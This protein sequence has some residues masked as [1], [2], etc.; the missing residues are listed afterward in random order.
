VQRELVLGARI[1]TRAAPGYRIATMAL[2]LGGMPKPASLA[3]RGRWGGQSYSLGGVFLDG[4]EPAPSPFGKAFDPGA[5]PRIRS[6]HLPWNGAADFTWEFWRHQLARN[7]DRRYVSD[8]DPK[9]VT[10][11]RSEQAKLAPRFRPL[12]RTY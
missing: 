12:A 2:P 1:I 11:P 9:R 10:F 6:S 4:A 5:I 8:G 3:R 7:P